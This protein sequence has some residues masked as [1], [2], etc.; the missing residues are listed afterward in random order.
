MEP[1][2]V[3]AGGAGQKTRGKETKQRN[4]IGWRLGGTFGRDNEGGKLGGTF[5]RDNDGGNY[6]SIFL[7]DFLP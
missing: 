1:Q 2:P 7:L 4:G 5:S 6:R 3:G